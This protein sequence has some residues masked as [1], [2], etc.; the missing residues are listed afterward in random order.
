MTA[1]NTA[2]ADCMTM[3]IG[4][5][6]SSTGRVIIGHNED[7][8]GRFIVR[9]GYVPPCDHGAEFVPCEEGHAAIPQTAHTVGFYWSEVC[10][11]SRGAS[12]SDLMIN[13]NG[14]CIV[15]NSSCGSRE[16]A[17]N[18]AI[19]RD[20]GIEYNIRRI[21]AERAKNA[22][23]GA[24]IIRQ[25]A[26]KWGY[27]ASGRLYTVA[28]S[29]EAFVIQLMRGQRYLAVRVPDDAV[30]AMPNHY[31][32][33]SRRD[34][35]EVLYS[36]DLVSYAVKKG[37]A[38]SEEDF[39]FYEAYQSRAHYLDPIN[40]LRQGHALR[41][42]AGIAFDRARLP[43]SVKVNRAYAVK[44]VMNVLS[45]HYEGTPDDT[46]FGP[47]AS[48]HNTGATR[49][50]RGSTIE[51]TV[52]EFADHP[53]DVTAWTAFGRPCQQPF[54]PLH[55]LCG[56]VD[57]LDRMED[58]AAALAAHLTPARGGVTYQHSGWQKLRDFGNMAEFFYGTCEA[59]LHAFRD[60][61]YEARS[62]ANRERTVPA[63]Q[64]DA[65]QAA[66]ALSAVE[67]FAARHFRQVQVSASVQESENRCL[68]S[69][70]CGEPPREESLLFGVGCLSPRT[71]YAHALPGSLIQTDSRRYQAEFPL[72]DV[73]CIPLGE[74]AFECFLGGNTE[75]GKPFAGMTL[76]ERAQ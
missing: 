46:R 74:G 48:P 13:D 72:S 2:G 10:G 23:D 31:I 39:D 37:W 68:V 44:D 8:G 52:V 22:R 70:E 54:I 58:P 18:E 36:P 64:F 32:V 1:F 34:A 43:F 42:L 62:R 19:L 65:C 3:I 75:Q 69:F 15:S 17:A 50:C 55:P 71:Q 53:K 16:E 41:Q 30:V 9:H 25:L 5:K 59:E 21:A 26:E 61:W 14:V 38:S 20:G 47:G 27:A 40:L 76:I 11:P 73:F 24:E 57:A 66:D 35:E 49:I 28:D 51:S 60:E 4:R 45:S 67:A 6:A 33:R 63:A 12:N 56:T 7:D 29:Q